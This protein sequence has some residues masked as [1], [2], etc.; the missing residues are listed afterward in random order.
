VIKIGRG[1]VIFMSKA[2][3][4]VMQVKVWEDKK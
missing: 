4:T 2:D 1:E 3:K